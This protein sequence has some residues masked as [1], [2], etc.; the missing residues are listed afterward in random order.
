M[1]AHVQAASFR[2]CHRP[3]SYSQCFGRLNLL[4]FLE[5][6]SEEEENSEPRVPAM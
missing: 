5:E 4:V 3:S 1:P 6:D 2:P